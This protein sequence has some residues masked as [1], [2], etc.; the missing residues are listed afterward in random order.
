MRD[1]ATERELMVRHDIAAR[2]IRDQRVLAAMRS[3]PR[4]RFLPDDMVEF[5]YADTPLPIEE[6]QTISQ[7]FIVANMIATIEPDAGDRV[8][9]IGTGSGYAAAVLSRV[10]REVYTVERHEP[11]ARLAR[12]RLADLGMDNVQVLHGDGTLGWPAHAPYDAIIVTAGGPRVPESLRAQLAIGGRLVMPVGDESRIQQLIRVTR[13][14]DDRFE[15]E[16]LGE[17]RF[18]PLIGQ[19]GFSDPGAPAPVMKG[20]TRSE[21]RRVGKECRSRWSPYH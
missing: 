3:V 9:E 1:F 16:E 2:G 7:P 15:E 8:L 13:L 14:D 5:A 6:G 12:E 19:E 4:E 10:V 18:V 21:E 17:V 11:L 20:R